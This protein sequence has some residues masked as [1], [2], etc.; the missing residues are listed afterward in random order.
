M[1]KNWKTTFAG[2]GAGALNLFAQGVNWKTVLFSTGL[3]V[4]GALAK[5]N[6]VTGGTVQQ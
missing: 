6:N 1:F 2:F 5:D 4:F 3:A